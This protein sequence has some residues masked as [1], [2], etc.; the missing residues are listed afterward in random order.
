VVD[1][2]GFRTGRVRFYGIFRNGVLVNLDG[3]R[4]D[5]TVLY[6]PIYTSRQT[7]ERAIASATGRY[8]KQLIVF[9]LRVIAE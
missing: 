4:D 5:D 3:L 7:A 8:R 1:V 9:P 2:N 6:P